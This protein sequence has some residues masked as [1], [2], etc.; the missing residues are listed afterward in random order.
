M[1]SADLRAEILG[2]LENFRD[3]PLEG[4]DDVEESLGWCATVDIAWILSD[5]ET[6][7]FNAYLVTR[8]ATFRR[9][10]AVLAALEDEGL[11]EADGSVYY[12]DEDRVWRAF[13]RLIRPPDVKPSS[14]APEHGYIAQLVQSLLGDDYGTEGS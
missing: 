4:E 3:L 5:T 8:S 9:V 14:V 2:I 11:I 7:A 1:D 13:W 6:F 12:D 10:A